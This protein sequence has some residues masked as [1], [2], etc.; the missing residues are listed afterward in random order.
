MK[1]MNIF[2]KSESRRRKKNKFWNVKTMEGKTALI[3]KR[4]RKT[5]EKK[6][7]KR[8]SDLRRSSPTKEKERER[9]NRIRR[10]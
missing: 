2:L 8:E 6:I 7:K 1:K 9:E 10:K 5:N 4:E 3:A